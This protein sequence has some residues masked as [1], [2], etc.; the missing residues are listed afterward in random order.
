MGMNTEKWTKFVWVPLALEALKLAAALI[1]S[2]SETKEKITKAID[3][4]ALKWK[5]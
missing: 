3:K 1:F 5:F 2:G 4:G